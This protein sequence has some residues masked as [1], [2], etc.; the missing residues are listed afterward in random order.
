MIKLTHCAALAAALGL[1]A[2][3]APGG[4]SADTAS[5]KRQTGAVYLV[6]GLPGKSVTAKVDGG[7]SRPGLEAGAEPDD[8]V[9]RHA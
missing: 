6:Q 9:R 1:V 2:L 4:A 7:A 5:V 3:T 8:A